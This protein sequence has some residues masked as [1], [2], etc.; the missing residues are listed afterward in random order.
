MSARIDDFDGDDAHL[1]SCIDALLDLDDAK[2][3]VP[4]GLGKG[5][6]AYR[7]LTAASARLAALSAIGTEGVKE[8]AALCSKRTNA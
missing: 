4:H 8:R 2:A 3:L 5:S 1:I 6:H 7:L